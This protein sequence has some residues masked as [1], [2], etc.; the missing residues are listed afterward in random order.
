M[1]KTT[2]DYDF[3]VCKACGTREGS[4]K[5]RLRNVNVF[6]CRACGFH[7]SDRLDPLESDFE[8]K[9]SALTREAA[10]YIENQLQSN[11]ERTD[12]HVRLIR[13]RGE[14]SGMRILDI[15]CGGGLFLGKARDA[16]AETFGIELSD[17]RARYAA[18]VHGLNV[19]KYPVEH[20]H[21]QEQYAEYFDIV[22]LWDVIEH[23]NFPVD[24]LKAAARLIKPNGCLFL[25]APIRD[26]FYHRFGAVTY[27]LSAGRFPTF[28][29]AMYSSE[30]FGH[31]QILA[32][33]E[34]FRFMEEAGL[35]LVDHRR[36]HELSFPYSFYLRKL[37]GSERLARLTLPVVSGFFRLFQIRNKVIAIACRTAA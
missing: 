22:T 14:L 8:L 23:V 10:E 27:R 19:V 34:L 30:K 24:L 4:Q 13:E 33:K 1:S 31:K 36:I 29:N 5:Y 32:S 12:R 26:A 9:P 17:A 3:T 11:A 28:L 16:G 6:V 35:T 2:L 21:W 25:D 20:D 37:L 7:Y 18:E 15:G